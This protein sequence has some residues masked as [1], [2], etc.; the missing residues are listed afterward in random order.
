MKKKTQGKK[1]PKHEDIGPFVSQSGLMKPLIKEQIEEYFNKCLA[2]KLKKKGTGRK[3]KTP[4]PK[5]KRGESY[6]QDLLASNYKLNKP[7][8]AID[9]RNIS[10][11][12]LGMG[13]R[14]R[15]RN[16]TPN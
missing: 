15:S 12:D 13:I 11:T 6:N 14:G 9:L 10:V 2:L 3:A 7:S 16:V 8:D 5:K 1:K 4:V